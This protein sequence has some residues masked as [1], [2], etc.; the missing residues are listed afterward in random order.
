MGYFTI[1][2]E[3]DRKIQVETAIQLLYGDHSS[4]S[5]DNLYESYGT[6]GSHH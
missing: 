3:G 6:D 2:L 4:E 5:H 1:S